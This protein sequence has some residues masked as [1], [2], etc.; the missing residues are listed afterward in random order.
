[1]TRQTFNRKARAVAKMLSGC[2]KW[3]S[4]KPKLA[5]ERAKMLICSEGTDHAN[6]RDGFCLCTHVMFE[7]EPRRG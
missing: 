4:N 2:S 7:E 5:L 1:M 6:R 3:Y